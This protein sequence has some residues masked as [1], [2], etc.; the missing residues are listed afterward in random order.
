ME[1]EITWVECDGGPHILI[2][3]KYL[4][5]WK[6]ETEEEFR[7]AAEYYEKTAT[8]DDYIGELQI[9]PGK[10]LVISEDIPSSTWI[11]GNN[12]GGFI[13]VINDVSDGFGIDQMHSGT[14]FHEFSGIA[15]DQ[16]IDT[17]IIYQV[18]DGDLYLLAACDFGSGWLYN[19]CCLKLLPGDYQIKMIEKYLF[20][21]ACFRLFRFC[22]YEQ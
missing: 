21:G 1:K 18:T 6:G 11:S 10:C 14:L 20:G 13:V 19:H 3:N 9:G 2:E 7:K 5:L 15:E 12:T 16:F 8:I 22:L 4:T 17:N